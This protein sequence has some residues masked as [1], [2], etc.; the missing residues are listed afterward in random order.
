MTRRQYAIWLGLA[1]FGLVGAASVI[2]AAAQTGPGD[3]ARSIS[4]DGRNLTK[5]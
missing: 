4:F 1:V 2:P 3:Y 5:Y